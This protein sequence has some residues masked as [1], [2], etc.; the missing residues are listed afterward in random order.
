VLFFAAGAAEGDDERDGLPRTTPFR[1]FDDY[2]KRG[3][4]GKAQIGGREAG[5]I[6]DF[7]GRRFVLEVPDESGGMTRIGAAVPVEGGEVVVE[8]EVA[9]EH[10]EKE[11]KA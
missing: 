1:N 4:G 5:K 6:G 2:L 8:F 10:A 3:H 11:R 7:E 9:T